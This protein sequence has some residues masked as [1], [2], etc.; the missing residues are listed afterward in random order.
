MNQEEKIIENLRK[1]PRFSW[2]ST[3]ICPVDLEADLRTKLPEE[4]SCPFTIKKRSGTQKGIQ[5][6]AK[7]SA[8][9]VIPESN[10]KMLNK[11]N[12]KRWH[13]LHKKDGDK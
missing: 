1:C 9:K 4:K 8:L 5:T 6:Q 3:N 2:C 10:A 13:A 11:G 7:D 12:F